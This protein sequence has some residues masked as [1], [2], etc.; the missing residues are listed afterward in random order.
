MPE[1]GTNSTETTRTKEPIDPPKGNE[2]RVKI[3]VPFEEAVK[4]LLRVPPL[5]KEQ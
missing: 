2:K 3:D 4:R 5:E 1:R